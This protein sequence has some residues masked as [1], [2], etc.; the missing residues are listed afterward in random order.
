MTSALARYH[1]EASA[2]P[3]DIAQVRARL[4]HAEQSYRHARYPELLALLPGLLDAARAARVIRPGRATDGLLVRAYGLIALALVKVDQR[5]LAWLAADRGMAVAL[6]TDAPRVA[7]VA[8]VPLSQALRAAGRRRSAAEVAVVAAHRV[9]PCRAGDDPLADPSPHGTLLLQAALAAAGRGDERTTRE[10][11]DRAARTALDAGAGGGRGGPAAVEA[12]RVVAGF[13]FGDV[14]AA[15]V[16]HQQLVAGDEW[17]WLPPE[18]R[19]AYLLDV[20]RAYAQTGDMLRA[21]R[22][23]LEAERTARGEV[24]DRPAVRELV[25]VVARSA[26]APAGVARLAAV[27][28]VA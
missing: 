23:V 5:E 6:T 12:A 10:L 13:A 21:G 26:A 4:D 24:H 9:M 7:A 3:S 25:A 11:L 14:A 1:I 27:L 28:R 2:R 15:T 19:A 17:R 18:H 8:A 22:T 20:A 16:R